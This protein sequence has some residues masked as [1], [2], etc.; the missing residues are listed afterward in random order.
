M[1]LVCRYAKVSENYKKYL[2]LTGVIVQIVFL[3]V[4]GIFIAFSIGYSEETQPFDV[5]KLMMLIVGAMLIVIGNYMPKVE[6]NSTLGFKSKWAKYNEVTWQKSQRFAGIASC[7]CGAIMMLGGIFFQEEVNTALL[8]GVM[9]SF[10]VT[11]MAASY[12]YY[13]VEKSKE[14]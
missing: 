11:T 3:A 12:Y 4:M 6:K 2:L 14:E 5:S 9:I 7:I 13:K 8:A 10:I 1:L